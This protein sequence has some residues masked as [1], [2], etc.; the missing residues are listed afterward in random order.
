M[1]VCSDDLREQIFNELK[2]GKSLTLSQYFDDNPDLKLY[3]YRFGAER[4]IN[5]LKAGKIW[6]G[7]A[8]YMDD[9]YDSAFIPKEDWLKLYQYMC[10]QEPKFK[11]DRYARVMT[12]QGKI[13]QN[14]LYICSLAE[15]AQNEDL[16]ARYAGHH[17]GFCIEYRAHDLIRAGRFLFPIYYG[18]INKSIAEFNTKNKYSVIFDIILKKCASQWRQQGEWRLIA[19]Y[20]SLGISPGDKGT[21]INAPTPTNMFCGKNAST[22]LKEALMAVSA[23]IHVPLVLDV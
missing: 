2:C 15:T 7:C 14:E 12:S 21:L 11:E 3:K 4:D 23:S 20:S 5:A 8:A 19:W 6:M 13:F 17:S 18:D 1:N 22:E 10:S 9:A 16:W